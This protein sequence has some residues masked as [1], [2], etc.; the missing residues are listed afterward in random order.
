MVTLYFSI[1]RFISK[2]C[3][4][5]DS[6]VLVED[7]YNAFILELQHHGKTVLN[8]ATF[9]RKLLS[10]FPSCVKKKRRCHGTK[11]K[12]EHPFIEENI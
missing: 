8:R 4:S 7:A 11:D 10:V 3:Y 6:V 2:F 1:F 12:Y 5:A 9:G